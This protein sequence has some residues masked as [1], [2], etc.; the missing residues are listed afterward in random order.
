[1]FAR[2]VT[3]RLRLNALKEFTSLME[4]E[5]LPWLQKQEGF[6]D[7]IILAVPD[8]GEVTTISFWD[9]EGDAQAYNSSGYPEVLKILAELLDGAPY[10]KTFN[11]VS[12]TLHASTRPQP[13]ES[14]NRVPETGSG[15]RGYRS[16]QT[17][18]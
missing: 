5:V 3:A 1:M 14:G 9:H 6:L 18:V 12:S 17:S 13:P 15:Q 2:K 16:Y 7:L 4:R 11:V 10:V 8:G